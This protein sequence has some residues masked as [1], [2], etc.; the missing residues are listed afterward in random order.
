MLG[1]FSNDCH[2]S[3][4]TLMKYGLWEIVNKTELNPGADEAVGHRKFTSRSDHAIS[5]SSK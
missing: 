4:M 3:T 2:V 1:S 5:K